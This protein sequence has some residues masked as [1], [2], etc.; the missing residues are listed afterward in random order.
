MEDDQ[1]EELPVYSSDGLTELH[2][3]PHKRVARRGRRV[4]QNS[5]VAMPFWSSEAVLCN[6]DAGFL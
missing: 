4:N 1:C 6:W 5:G 3:P 2:P